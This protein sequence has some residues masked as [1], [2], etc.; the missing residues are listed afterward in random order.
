M[1]F[2]LMTRVYQFVTDVLIAVVYYGFY[3]NVVSVRFSCHISKKLIRNIHRFSWAKV[4]QRE[5]RA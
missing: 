4:F 3:I 1:L 5:E 2:E